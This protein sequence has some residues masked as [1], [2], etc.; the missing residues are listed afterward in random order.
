MGLWKEE[1]IGAAARVSSLLKNS[2][3][4]SIFGFVHQAH[5]QITSNMLNDV[6]KHRLNEHD[7]AAPLDF[8]SFVHHAKLQ[9]AKGYF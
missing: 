2:D 7:R 9:A 6:I 1:G 4:R 3:C 8:L 5:T